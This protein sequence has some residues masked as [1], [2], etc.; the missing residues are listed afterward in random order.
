MGF[1]SINCVQQLPLKLPQFPSST[2]RG[3]QWKE[4]CDCWLYLKIKNLRLS[5]IETKQWSHQEVQWI[6]FMYEEA[7]GLRNHTAGN[8]VKRI[9][10]NLLFLKEINK[11]LNPIEIEYSKNLWCFKP[12][13]IAGLS[14]GLVFSLPGNTNSSSWLLRHL[15]FYE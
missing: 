11:K 4:C 15:L 12:C 3:K 5:G 8:S 10:N 13:L 7:I 1:I 14:L 9:K 6:F 2:W